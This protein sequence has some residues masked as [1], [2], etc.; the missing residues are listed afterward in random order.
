MQQIAFFLYTPCSSK[1][2]SRQF[3]FSNRL[4]HPK[5]FQDTVTAHKVPNRWWA[6]IGP[7]EGTH[8][9]QKLVKLGLLPSYH[10]GVVFQ[11]E[12]SWERS[13]WW[14]KAKMKFRSV[15]MSAVELGAEAEGLGDVEE[16]GELWIHWEDKDINLGGGFKDFLFLPGYLGEMRQF[17]RICFK[18]V[19]TSS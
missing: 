8:L 16:V 18:W 9:L 1:K 5:T 13:Q 11:R 19:E 14:R 17:W 15:V 10:P 3:G 2:T 4:L 12:I 7:G 6:K